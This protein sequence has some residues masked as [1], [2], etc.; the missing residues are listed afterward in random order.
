VWYNTL[1]PRDYIPVLLT[2]GAEMLA[3]VLPS[4]EDGPTGLNRYLSGWAFAETSETDS[5]TITLWDGPENSGSLLLTLVIPP[6]VSLGEDYAH[7]IK[8]QNGL[9]T[10]YSGLGTV[11]G[12]V[13]GQA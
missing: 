8:L 13:R 10:Y 9:Y 3:D 1:V 5:I 12:T 2:I 6:G 7:P 11:A 4:V